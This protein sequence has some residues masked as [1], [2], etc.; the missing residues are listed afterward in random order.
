MSLSYVIG[1]PLGAWLAFRFG[2]PWPF[3]L[4][5]GMSLLLSLIHI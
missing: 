4:I 3:V 5:A 1:V 2:W